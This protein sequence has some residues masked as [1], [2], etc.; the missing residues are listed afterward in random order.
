MDD[1]ANR[2]EYA[3]VKAAYQ[4]GNDKTLIQKIMA[5]AAS[6]LNVKQSATDEEIQAEIDRLAENARG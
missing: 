5:I 3:K 4:P 2:I 6:A 1:F